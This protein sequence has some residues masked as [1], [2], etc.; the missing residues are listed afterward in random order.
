MA[1]FREFGSLRTP[2]FMLP[3]CM[4]PDPGFQKMAESLEFGRFTTGV[5]PGR[6]GC[7]LSTGYPHLVRWGVWEFELNALVERT[8]LLIPV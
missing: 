3:S 1:V 8:C 6:P 5:S 7:N 2:L 4:V